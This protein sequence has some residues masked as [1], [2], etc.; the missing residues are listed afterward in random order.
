MR[1]GIGGV[2][3]EI[4]WKITSLAFVF[5]FM[6]FSLFF[7]K[8]VVKKMIIFPFLSSSILDRRDTLPLYFLVESFFLPIL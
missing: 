4:F 3:I 6:V 5:I 7:S 8:E 2:R 1:L